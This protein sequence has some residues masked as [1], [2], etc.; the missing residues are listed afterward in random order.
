MFPLLIASLMLFH[1][2]DRGFVVDIAL[3]EDRSTRLQGVFIV[4]FPTEDA[5]ESMRLAGILRD[6]PRYRLIATSRVDSAMQMRHE[7]RLVIAA[8]RIVHAEGTV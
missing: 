6:R 8:L 7:L 1:L 5:L 3:I 4:L 2:L